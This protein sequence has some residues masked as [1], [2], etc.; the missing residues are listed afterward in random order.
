MAVCLDWRIVIDSALI[1]RRD[2]RL[3]DTTL[4][5][6][7]IAHLQPYNDSCILSAI[8]A[9]KTIYIFSSDKK[10]IFRD[11]IYKIFDKTTKQK[12]N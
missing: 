3:I 10:E 2:E 6:T 5:I 7:W 8:F 11:I 4:P 1:A 9:E 12:A